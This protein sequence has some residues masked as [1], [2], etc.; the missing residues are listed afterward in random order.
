MTKREKRAL[1]GALTL[2]DCGHSLNSARRT[3]LHRVLCTHCQMLFLSVDMT[4]QPHKGHKAP[5]F[6]CKSA[7][8]LLF[9]N[10]KSTSSIGHAYIIEASFLA[11]HALVRLAYASRQLAHSSRSRNL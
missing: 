4:T 6:G 9:K 3:L 8:I 1:R 7:L 10:A 5:E 11:S 2:A